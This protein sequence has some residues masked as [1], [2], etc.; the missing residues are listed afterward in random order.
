MKYSNKPFWFKFFA[1]TFLYCFY[2]SSLLVV[3]CNLMPWSTL[4][5]L[6]EMPL[7]FAPR[8]WVISLLLPVVIIDRSLIVKQWKMVLITVPFAFY[9]LNFQLP[10][11]NI[12]VNSV[13][14][15]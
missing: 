5:G 9:Y 4:W 13:G 12:F 15:S 7:L 6:I 11:S 1:K 14:K 8:W 2:F 10:I 3:L